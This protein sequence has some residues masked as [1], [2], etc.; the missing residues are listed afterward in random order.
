MTN[1][2][3]CGICFLNGNY[4]EVVVEMSDISGEEI[5]FAAVK[6]YETRGKGSFDQKRIGKGLSSGNSMNCL[7]NCS[8]I[9]ILLL[10]VCM[11]QEVVTV[12]GW[13]SRH[14]FGSDGKGNV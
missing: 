9:T 5:L 3:S 8:K 13:Q 2:M 10:G 6:L 12:S 1:Q 4:D 11:T 14:Q 7:Q